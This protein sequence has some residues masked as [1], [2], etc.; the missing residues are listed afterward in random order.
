MNG[1][2]PGGRPDKMPRIILDAV[3]EAHLLHHL[4]I[5]FRAHFEPLRLEQF[6][7]RFELDDALVQF[8]ADRA[9]ARD[10]TC[11]PA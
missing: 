9:S 11:P 1:F 6:A 8:V 10:S 4:E 7:L 5:V 2:E 3:A